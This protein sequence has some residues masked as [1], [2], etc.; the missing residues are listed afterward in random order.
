MEKFKN[1]YRIES[2]R[3]Q[4]WDYGANGLYFITICTAHRECYFGDI[5]VDTTTAPIMQLSEIGNIA[6]H[7][8]T[9]IPNHF[10]FVELGEFVVMP[11]HIHGIIV[12]NKTDD[13]R[14]NVD[15]DADVAPDAA[16]A[17]DA[18]AVT[19]ATTTVTPAAT[20]VT[21][22]AATANPNRQQTINASKKWYPNTLGVIINQ[23]KRM[24]TIHARRIHAGYAW[25]E[26]FHDHIIRDNSEYQRISKYIL[27]NP[28]KWADD[29]FFKSNLG[30]TAP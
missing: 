2:A 3:L 22:N 7:F 10:P 20:T 1:K 14:T 16:V 30:G 23:Y 9:E 11:N 4:N 19:P 25:Q 6:Q 17:P 13:K 15:V 26:R 18:D 29:K 28:A 21:N 12:I 24:V 27:N 5:L 8:W